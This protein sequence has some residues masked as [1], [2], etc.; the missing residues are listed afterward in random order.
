MSSEN[1]SPKRVLISFLGNIN[2]D[3]RSVNLCSSLRNEGLTIDTLSFDWIDR[4]Q[5]GEIHVIKLDKS[6]SSLFFYFKFFY[7]VCSKL[8]FNKYDLYIASDIYNLPILALFAEFRGKPLYYDSRELFRYLAGLK[9]KVNIQRLLA[10]IEES[11]IRKCDKVIVTGMMDAEVLTEDYR[12]N[13]EKFILLRNLPKRVKTV[14]KIDLRKLYGFPEN[15]LILLYQGVI[16]KG[17]GLHKLISLLPAIDDLC[18]VILG[19][20][21]L[22]LELENYVSELQMKDRVKFTGTIS[23]NELLSYTAS[24][25]IGCVLI[26]N[27]SRSYYY[28]LPNKLFEY[29]AVGI[30]VLASNLPQMVQIIDEYGVG[31]YVDP[32]NR[33]EIID[34]VELF[35]D[36]EFRKTIKANAEIAHQ[37]LNWDSEYLLVRHHFV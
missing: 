20:G 16:L 2:Y 29:I 21:D 13:H 26:E 1:K 22:R 7:S 30:P 25:D 12:I 24:A 34:V 19:D 8:I 15:S 9:N 31:K 4:K 17:R 14:E 6:K 11:F 10:K 27:I 23:Q 3:T 33:Q 28:A 36:S 32:D 18:L 5:G 37:R 35:R